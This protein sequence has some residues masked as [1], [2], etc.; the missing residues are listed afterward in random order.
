MAKSYICTLNELF[1]LDVDESERVLNISKI[2]IPL[3]QRDYAQGREHPDITRIRK[4]FLGSLKQA[5]LEEPICLDFIYGDISDDGVLTPL[6]GQQRITTL[7][8]LYWYAAK[9]ENVSLDEYKFLSNFSYETRPSS[10]DFCKLLFSF[11]PD[12]DRASLKEQIVDQAW[13]PLDWKNDPTIKSMLVM[14]DEINKTFAGLEN[15]W[16]LLSE[17]KKIQFYFLPIRNMGLTDELYIKMNSRGKPLT[18][19]EHFK[20][21]LEHEI[22]LLDKDISSEL[23]KKLDLKWTDFLWK[24]RKEDC[25][26]DN[27]FLNFFKYICDIICYEGDGTPQGRSYDEFDLI[28]L[29]FSH[30]DPQSI[31]NIK[32]LM[33]AFDSFCDLNIDLTAE[34]FGLH[35]SKDS[36]PNKAKVSGDVDLL[37]RCFSDYVDLRTGKRSLSFPLGQIVLLYGFLQYAMNYVSITPEQ[38]N[39]RIRIINNLITNS[40]DEMHD[41]E[42]RVGGNRLPAILKQTRSIIIDGV[43]LD[44]QS[45]GINFNA[46]QLNEEKEKMKWR[47]NNPGLVECLN[48]LENHDLLQG[49]ISIIG[50]ENSDVFSRFEPLFNC[51]RDLVSC[52]LLTVGD[53]SRIEKQC[54]R[55]FGTKT[56]EASWKFIFHKSS[57]EGFDKAKSILVELLRKNDIFT[58][59]YLESLKNEYIAECEASSIYDWRYYFIKYDE[60]RPDRF[61]KY[62]I[63]ENNYYCIYAMVT[64]TNISEYAFNPFLKA[65]DPEHID[66]ANLGKRL[67]YEDK[68]VYCDIDS[69]AIRDFDENLIRK[70]DITQNE[71]GI[72]TIDRIK[73]YKD[74]ILI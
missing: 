42:D 37:N 24:Y 48:M 25:L 15:I 35:L 30:D 60:F 49:Q 47:Q 63:K 3:I 70:I 4:K 72:D 7:F 62:W 41:S 38:F 45:I 67:K 73:A 26:V 29:Y 46:H 52:A 71:H 34:L 20:A 58:N 16:K 61:G 6:D 36:V 54:R 33:K 40:Q 13:F 74:A 10:R 18:V 55:T 66:K 14:I 2:S 5:L 21:E 31:N 11:T 23:E 65:I 64:K 27:L 57:A 51:D 59:E 44:S 22:R 50:L 12:F 43:F 53:Y 32:Y 9:K 17:E 19:F 1:N 28:D 8:L 69:F 56:N 68:F 39:E